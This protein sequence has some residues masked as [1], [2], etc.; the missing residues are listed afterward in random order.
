[1]DHEKGIRLASPQHS[2]E[3]VCLGALWLHVWLIVVFLFIWAEPVGWGVWWTDCRGVGAQTGSRVGG[4][5]KRWS[6]RER[7][8]FF[9]VSQCGERPG[10]LP[11]GLTALSRNVCDWR[12][13]WGC[14][15][16][17]S[18]E[19]KQCDRSRGLWRGIS[20]L[21]RSLC[22]YCLSSLLLTISHLTVHVCAC[23]SMGAVSRR[24]CEQK[25]AELISYLLGSCT[26]KWPLYKI[27]LAWDSFFFF[28]T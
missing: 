10:S 27:L 25:M 4:I 17:Y 15:L 11:A 6:Q 26:Q 13:G 9:G 23:V 24:Y 3:R 28:L 8:H 1:M 21:Q 20:T 14:A 18:T 2:P 16:S 7:G 5:E 19:A 12:P 22:F